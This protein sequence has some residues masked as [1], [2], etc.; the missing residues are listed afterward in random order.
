MNDW[1]P[2]FDRPRLERL[3]VSGIELK[4]GDRVRLHPMGR[5]DILDM[6]LDG[7]T[8]MIEAIEQDFEERVYVGVVL[9]DDPGRD[10]GQLRQPGHCFYFGVEEIEP[11]QPH[12]RSIEG[13]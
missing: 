13:P 7:K 2:L 3:R 8:A 10:L 6:A 9:D 11:F 5:A 12:S 1:D 4:P